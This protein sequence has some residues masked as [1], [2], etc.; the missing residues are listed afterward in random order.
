MADSSYITKTV[1][2][3]LIS[4]AG[5][6]LGE[7][8][9]RLR[10]K[11]GMGTSGTSVSFEFDGVNEARTV[12]VL[13]S[14]SKS[15]KSGAVRKLIAD[16]AILLA[17]PFKKKVLVFAYQLVRTNFENQFRGI[18]DLER[19]EFMVH[20]ELPE[21]MQRKLEEIHTLA[22]NEQLSKK[23]KTKASRNRR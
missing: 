18:L 8:L 11:L 23:E 19:I 12:G 16:A 15:M 13:A 9:F 20:P 1:E 21:C 17:S 5:N 3:F 7:T 14:A 2:P 6:E 22:R 4:W 10:E